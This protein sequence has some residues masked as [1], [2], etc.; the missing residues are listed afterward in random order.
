MRFEYL[1]TRMQIMQ[2]RL[3]QQFQARSPYPEMHQHP[4]G[5]HAI[6]HTSS[7]EH[8]RDKLVRFSKCVPKVRF[9][10][11]HN[12]NDILNMVVVLS[13]YCYKNTDILSKSVR[14][15]VYKTY[16]FSK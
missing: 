5:L 16:I 6:N 14:K 9:F 11:M 3:N 7:M 1:L 12:G 2:D 15:V 4:Q 8:S 13:G 10:V